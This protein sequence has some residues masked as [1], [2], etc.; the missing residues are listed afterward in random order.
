MQ[1]G[2]FIQERVLMK[3]LYYLFSFILLIIG[4]FGYLLL[5]SSIVLSV[6]GTLSMASAAFQAIQMMQKHSCEK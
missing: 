6:F 2:S 5:G 1:H 3:H 4:V